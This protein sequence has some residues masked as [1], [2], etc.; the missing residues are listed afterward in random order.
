[1][2]IIAYVFKYIILVRISL[3]S[4]SQTCVRALFLEKR[5]V[6]DHTSGFLL[7]QSMCLPS[8]TP[9]DPVLF[10][11]PVA[12]AQDAGLVIGAHVSAEQLRRLH[13]L[14]QVLDTTRSMV[15]TSR[16]VPQDKRV[17]KHG[18]AAQ[19]SLAHF[20][21]GMCCK[22]GFKPESPNQ[23]DFFVIK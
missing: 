9:N 6:G 22:K 19:E 21:I 17:E 11:S 1:M 5:F 7:S 4:L 23:D 10:G 8:G 18:H 2:H 14:K 16:C 3:S 20:G 12:H 13:V 15:P